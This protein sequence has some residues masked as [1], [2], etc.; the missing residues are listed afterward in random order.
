MAKKPTI[1]TGPRTP[2]DPSRQ[3]PKTTFGD[4]PPVP[5]DPPPTPPKENP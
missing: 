2:V 4:R 1:R 3:T 5:K